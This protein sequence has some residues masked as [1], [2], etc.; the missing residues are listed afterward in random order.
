[1]TSTIPTGCL[2]TDLLI[3]QYPQERD[4]ILQHA[5]EDRRR[6]LAMYTELRSLIGFHPIV[7]V[8]TIVFTGVISF[9]LVFVLAQLAQIALWY[10]KLT[11]LSITIPIPALGARTVDLGSYVPTSTT[12]EL[13]GQLPVWTVRDCLLFATGVMLVVLISMGIRIAIRWRD[14][15][16][17]KQGEVQLKEELNYLITL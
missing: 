15:K 7:F 16:Q 8:K 12:F 5:I 17:L 1:M 9:V 10:K 2:E 3:K 14:A 13:I 11:E 6:R 4:R